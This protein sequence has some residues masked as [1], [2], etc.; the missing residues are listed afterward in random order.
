MSGQRKIN[1]RELLEQARKAAVGVAGASLLARSAMASDKPLGANDRIRVAFVGT[2]GQGQFDLRI[3]LKEQ[4]VEVPVVCD[5]N[6]LNAG[7]ARKVADDEP[8][9]IEDY[10]KILDRKDVDAVCIAT[11]DHW[12]AIITIA[13]CQ[14]G[15]DVYVEK[16]MTLCVAEGRRM[17]EAARKHNRIVQ[18]GTQQHSGE[19]YAQARE[20][21]QSGALGKVHHVRAW[22]LGNR[23][24]GLKKPPHEEVPKTLNYDMWLG[25]R[26]KVPYDS[27]RCSGR[28]RYFWDYAGGTV[29]DWGTHHMETVQ[30]VMNA[31]AP[32][33]ATAAGGKLGIDDYRDVPDT[34]N[35][36][37]EYPGWTLEY[38]LREASA[39]NK[40]GSGYGIVFH[41]TKAALYLDRSGYEL[42]PEGGE[43]P[44][45]VVGTPR[46]DNF[47]PQV[48]SVRHIRNFLECMVSR[49]LPV[50]D[51]EVGQRA[52]TVPHLG[53]IAYR[54]GHKIRWDAEKEQILDD[55][56]A[57]ALL[58]RE[59]RAPY[60]LPE[61]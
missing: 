35:V 19:H 10:R 60:V 32:L 58:T 36:L 2:A 44:A 45:T 30:W 53:N 59:Y 1:R 3:F 14:A 28:H 20:V 6:Q 7:A 33:S 4:N 50:V 55:K 22:N 48:L 34:L 56:E 17:V 39:F 21:V 38:T 52:T 40:E 46:K 27:V 8:E 41:G 12:H 26:P 43:T 11:P 29:T 18:V 13:A 37:W 57:S 42:M 5:V 15:K 23:W 61:V 25:P 9:V 16:P 24:P 47:L 49:K 51:V 54:T 31:R